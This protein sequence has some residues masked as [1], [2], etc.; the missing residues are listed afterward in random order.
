[1]AHGPQ[2]CEIMPANADESAA[3]VYLSLKQHNTN[4]HSAMDE[5]YV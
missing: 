4:V 1:M 5:S 2:R 3:G